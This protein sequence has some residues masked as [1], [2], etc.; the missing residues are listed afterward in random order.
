MLGSLISLSAILVM[1]QSQTPKLLDPVKGKIDQLAKSCPDLATH[2]RGP[3]FA[4]SIPE[5]GKITVLNTQK[6]GVKG[7]T[8]Q[9]DTWLPTTFSPKV[10][11]T[12]E[13]KGLR[14][15]W[16]T[17]KGETKERSYK[18]TA[19][20]GYWIDAEKDGSLVLY[21]LTK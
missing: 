13:I 20:R 16:T 19:N 8:L 17:T 4:Q 18:I 11:S 7:A 14:L 5:D 9:G 12:R 21:I 3:W 6:T 1:G 15:S 10:V 2:V